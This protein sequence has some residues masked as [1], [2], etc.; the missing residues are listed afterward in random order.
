[1]I[2]G[3]IIILTG[4]LGIL[5]M[6]IWLAYRISEF[7]KKRRRI[8]LLSEDIGKMAAEGVRK[9]HSNGVRRPDLPEG[10]TVP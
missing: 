2:D 3:K 7:R 10:E 9:A 8:E 4:L 1:M 6:A 5:L